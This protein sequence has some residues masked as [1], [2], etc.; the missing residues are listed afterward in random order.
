MIT[1][2]SVKAHLAVFVSEIEGFPSTEYHKGLADFIAFLER[3]AVIPAPPP[4]PVADP[5][6]EQPVVV[7]PAPPPEPVVVPAALS[8]PTDGMGAAV[9]IES[10]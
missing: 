6:A 8:N 9:I 1:L 4:E 10:P 5:V 3:H 7:V 2:A